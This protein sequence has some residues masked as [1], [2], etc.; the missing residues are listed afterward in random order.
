[1]LVSIHLA[2]K[3]QKKILLCVCKL[4]FQQSEQK[5]WAL[6]NINKVSEY[7]FMELID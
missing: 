7:L 3:T 2:K 6:N 5:R 1:M 4:K